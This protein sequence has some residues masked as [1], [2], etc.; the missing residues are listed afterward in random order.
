MYYPYLENIC[1]NLNLD[2]LRD[3]FEASKQKKNEIKKTNKCKISDNWGNH[4]FWRSHPSPTLQR[5]K[6]S[7][8]HF[9]RTHLATDV[10]SWSE[11]ALQKMQR[12]YSLQELCIVRSGWRLE[13]HHRRRGTLSCGK[14]QHFVWAVLSA[15]C[16]RSM[17]PRFHRITAKR[18]HLA[19]FSAR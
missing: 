7:A 8:L 12:S 10:N 1:L 3:Y 18:V 5:C 4:Y 13:L 6:G 17:A 2:H 15:Q 19:C 16:I 14:R 11:C 9:R